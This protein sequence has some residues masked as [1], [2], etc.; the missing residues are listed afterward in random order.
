MTVVELRPFSARWSGGAFRPALLQVTATVLVSGGGAAPSLKPWRTLGGDGHSVGVR[1]WDGHVP[2]PWRTASHEQ[3]AGQAVE[4]GSSSS[5]NSRRHSE[6]SRGSRGP[7]PPPACP[8]VSPESPMA[9]PVT[10]RGGRGYGYG[11]DGQ[12]Y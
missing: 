8:P 6:S 9:V 4:A 2:R 3:A 1:E 10:A 5:R 11:R 12:T 7:L